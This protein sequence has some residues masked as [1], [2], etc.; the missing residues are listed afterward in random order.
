MKP[1]AY[2]IAFLVLLSMTPTVVLANDSVYT[3]LDTDH[4]KTLSPEDEEGGGISLRC[5]GFKDYDVYFKEGDLRQ[6]LFYGHL[7]TAYIDGAFESFGPFNYTGPK[8]EWRLGAGGKPV[9]TIL[10]WFISNVDPETGEPAPALKGQVL[11]VSKVAGEDGK[12][13][14]V[15]YVDALANPDPNA[16]ARQIADTQAEG[17][18]CGTDTA[19]FT[20]VRGPRAADHTHSF[21]E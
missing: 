1:F 11:V 6:S 14:V 10:R 16:M 19:D 9:A 3:D 5:K 2:S 17:F 20:G 4:C 18:V 12:G 7:N 15:G 13:C 21:P 8:I